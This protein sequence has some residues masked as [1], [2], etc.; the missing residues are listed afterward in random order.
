[1]FPITCLCSFE[2]CGVYFS[3]LPRIKANS[4]TSSLPEDNLVNL[5]FFVKL[6]QK[7]RIVLNHTG[8]TLSL[9]QFSYCGISPFYHIYIHLNCYPIPR[10][11]NL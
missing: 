5:I 11:Q 2:Q 6:T 8:F 9:K 10:Q 3:R 1:M 4:A 7:E